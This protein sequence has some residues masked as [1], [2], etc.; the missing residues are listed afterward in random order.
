MLPDSLLQLENSNKIVDQR[1]LL[2][3]NAASNLFLRRRKTLWNPKNGGESI[4]NFFFGLLHYHYFRM[5]EGIAGMTESI[6]HESFEKRKTI[7]VE[8]F[9]GKKVCLACALR[10]PF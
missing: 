1:N 2:W 8:D 6:S 4:L 5:N 3:A 7:K 10:K 9:S